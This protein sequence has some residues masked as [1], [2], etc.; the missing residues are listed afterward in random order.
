MSAI[1]SIEVFCQ[2]VDNYG[3]VGVAWRLARQF[4]HEHG[5]AVTL[6]IDDLASFRRIRA[7]VDPALDLQQVA[8]V[9]VRRWHAGRDVAVGPMPDLVVEAFGCRL[10]DGYLARMAAAGRQ[11]PPPV[12]INLEYLS[13]EPWVEGCHRRASPH[14]TLPLTKYFFFPGFTGDTGGLLAERDLPR[15]R[16]ALRA[17]PAARAAAFDLLPGRPLRDAARL[18]DALVV[19]LFCYPQAPARAL[20]EAWRRHPG[21][22]E[23]IVPEGVAP[24]AVAGF[25]GMPAVAGAR[26]TRDALTLHV[27]PFVDQPDYDRLLWACD[28]NFVRGEDSFVRA[29]WAAQPFVWQIYPQEDDAHRVKLDAFLDRYTRDLDPRTAGAVRAF[30]LE[31]NTGTQDEEALARAWQDFAAVLPDARRHAAAWARALARRGDLA[32]NL[33]AFAETVR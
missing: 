18:A 1:R 20:F 27:A 2:V 7:D 15:L 32:S 5:C 23:C 31:W 6:W 33:L 8:Q 30:W 19:S 25:L 16:D 24:D 3:D 10:P 14:P 21:R 12:W 26:G 11:G 17:D 29:Q 13:A 4:R 28:L 9:C 22:I